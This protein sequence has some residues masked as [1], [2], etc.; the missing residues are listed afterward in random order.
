[1]LQSMICRSQMTCPTQEENIKEFA[2]DVNLCPVNLQAVAG[3]FMPEYYSFVYHEVEFFPIEN[4]VCFLA[5]SE[6][7][8]YVTEVAVKIIPKCR[9]VIH[10]DF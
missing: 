6:N 4:Q 10:E 3:N 9:E 8:L 1:M 5:S 7:F 2:Y